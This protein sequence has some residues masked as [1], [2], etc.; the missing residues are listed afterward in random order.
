M[1]TIT[2]TNLTLDWALKL[3]SEAALHV[4]YDLLHVFKDSVAFD[5]SSDHRHL[6]DNIRAFE[7]ALVY[8][9]RRLDIDNCVVITSKT[10]DEDKDMIISKF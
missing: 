9:H 3:H 10:E 5:N 1:N 4:Y 2:T 7:I 6:L 8:R